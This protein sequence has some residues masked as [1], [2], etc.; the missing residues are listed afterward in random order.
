MSGPVGRPGGAGARICERLCCHS[1]ARGLDKHNA[2][3][4]AIAFHGKELARRARRKCELCE[5]AED[6]RPYDV[7]REAAPSLD[8]LLLLCRR[9]RDVAEGGVEDVRTLRFLEGAVWHEVAVVADLARA[10][11]AKVDA[12]W[13]RDTLALLP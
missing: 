11:I 10:L 13:A 1:V 3:Q 5:G 12:P 4:D 9:C 2:R 7:D 6:L 8:T